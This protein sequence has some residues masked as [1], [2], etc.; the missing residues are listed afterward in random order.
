[1]PLYFPPLLQAHLPV[2]QNSSYRNGKIQTLP[3]KF[4]LYGL[5]LNLKKKKGVLLYLLNKCQLDLHIC[6]SFKIT[7]LKEKFTFFQKNNTCTVILQ[8][9][10]KKVHYFLLQE[11]VKLSTRPLM[12]CWTPVE[13][14]VYLLAHISQCCGSS[15]RT[16]RQ[17]PLRLWGLVFFYSQSTANE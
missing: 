10:K 12:P 11:P 13:L 17:Q 15:L 5:N 1:M 14:S 6:Q 2:H 16:T 4:I 8:V 9:K 7:C 3:T